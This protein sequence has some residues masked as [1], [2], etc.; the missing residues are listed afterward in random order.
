METPKKRG[1]YRVGSG[2]PK[3]TPTKTIAVR[4]PLDIAEI[5]NAQPNRQAFIN[6][7]LRDYIEKNNLL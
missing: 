7:A 1:G 4:V 5:I 3:G 6:A 2:R